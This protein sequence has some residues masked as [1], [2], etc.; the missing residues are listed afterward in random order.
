MRFKPLN[1]CASRFPERR[2]EKNS[3]THLPNLMQTIN[4]H[5]KRKQETWRKLP[6]ATALLSINTKGTIQKIQ[7][8]EDNLRAADKSNRTSGHL[9]S[10]DSKETTEQSGSAQQK[11]LT[12]Q[13]N[14]TSRHRKLREQCVTRNLLNTE[15]S[16]LVPWWMRGFGNLGSYQGRSYEG[17]SKVVRKIIAKVFSTV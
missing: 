1:L 4:S 13:R 15:A 8:E 12:T 17:N 16:P 6:Q 11:Q 7:P 14:R 3:G 2:K 10:M 9:Q 5:M